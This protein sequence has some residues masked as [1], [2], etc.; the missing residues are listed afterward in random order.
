MGL[1]HRC[2]LRPSCDGGESGAQKG[3]VGPDGVGGRV[4]EGRL[5]RRDVDAQCLSEAVDAHAGSGAVAGRLVGVDAQ[6]WPSMPK[7]GR[8]RTRGAVGPP[9]WPATAQRGQRRPSFA[10][11]HRAR[12]L[13]KDVTSPSYSCVG[14]LYMAIYRCFPVVGPILGIFFARRSMSSLLICLVLPA[15]AAPPPPPLRHGHLLHLLLH[16]VVLHCLHRPLVD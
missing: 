14:W 16:H 2:V 15:D 12:P 8:R 9:A 3:G 6:V 13:I 5:G 11:K 1:H 10:L 4:T 7:R